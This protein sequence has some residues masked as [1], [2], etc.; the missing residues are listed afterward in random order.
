MVTNLLKR[1]LKL[2]LPALL[3]TACS[4]AQPPLQQWQHSVQGSY[5]AAFSP[6]RRYVLVG[7]TEHPAKLWDLTT[8]TVKYSWQN[9]AD[10][11]GA[12]TDVAFSGNSKIAATCESE[13]IVLWNVSDGKPRTRLQFP[14]AVKD[15]AVSPQGDFLLVALQDRSAVYFDVA[16]N[17]VRQLFH[18]DGDPV[19]SPIDQLINSVAISPNGKYGLTG[20]DDNSARLWDLQTGQQLRRWQHGN[21][22]SLVAFDPSGTH[23]I[24]SAGND[25]TYIWNAISA[26][27]VGTLNTS[28][29]DVDSEWAK[30]PV[31]TTTTTAVAWSADRKF[32][33]TGHPNQQICTWQAKDGTAIACWKAPRREKLKPGVVIQA[34]MF[35]ADGQSIYSESGNGLAQ[36]WAF[37]DE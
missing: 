21:H 19:N 5:A 36:K 2:G 23:V 28:V 1:S 8:Q 24:S 6:D 14:F 4:N 34:L 22:V 29:I 20:G 33:A 9:V 26:E 17:R 27:K 11:M 30:L 16:A 37:N 15:M 3:L 35:S 13:T 31:F 32:V 10:E 25:Q 7:D 12:T 18:H